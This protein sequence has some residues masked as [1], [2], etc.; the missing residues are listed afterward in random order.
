[1][2][3]LSMPK[4]DVIPVLVYSNVGTA[5]NWLCENFGFTERLLIGN[6]RAQLNVGNAAIVITSTQNIPVSKESIKSNSIMVRIH[7]LDSHF[8]KVKKSGCNI[9]NEPQDYPYGERQYTVEDF[10]GRIWTFSQTI[11]NISPDKWG[12]IAKNLD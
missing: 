8:V 2:D 1:M 10:E 4:N 5:I 7:D 11:A 3:N 6:H 9:L 12:G